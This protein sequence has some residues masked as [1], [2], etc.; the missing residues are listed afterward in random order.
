VVVLALWFW[1]RTSRRDAMGMFVCAGLYR[2]ATTLADTIRVD[3]QLPLE[4]TRGELNPMTC[5]ALRVT[6]PQEVV[7]AQP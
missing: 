4:R 1:A 6:Y 2:G 3:G 5:G 7:P